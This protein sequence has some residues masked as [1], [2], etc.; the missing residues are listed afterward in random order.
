ML[1]KSQTT[2]TLRFRRFSHKA[3]AAFNSL[4]RVVNIGCVSGHIAD[5]QLEKSHTH[6]Q[7]TEHIVAKIQNSNDSDGEEPASYL[8]QAIEA[9]LI[10]LT[11]NQCDAAAARLICLY[12]FLKLSMYPSSVAFILFT[13]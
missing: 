5:L 4:H 6:Y 7:L 9:T 8:L 2:Q 11:L 3:Y 10:T 13:N 12:S 1:P